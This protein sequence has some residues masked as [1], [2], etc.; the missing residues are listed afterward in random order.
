MPR[1]DGRN[2]LVTGASTGIGRATALMLADLG[3][4]VYAG[5]RDVASGY[6]LGPKV[7]P[8]RLDVTNDVDVI[9]VASRIERL[10]GLVNNAGIAITGPLE[11]LPLDELRRQL[12]VNAIAALAVT[13]ACL[14]A[15]RRARGRIVNVSS[16]SGRSVLPLSG[17]YAASKYAL[18]A[19]S[20]ALRRELRG[21]GVQVSVVQPGSIATPIWER[22][23]AKADELWEAMPSTAH[24]RYGTLVAIVRAEA[25]RQPTA[26]APPE[27]VARVIAGALT[28]RR[29]RTRY[30][31]GR[32]AKARAALAQVLP[33]RAMDA[34]LAAALRTRR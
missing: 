12:E 9:D 28:A 27:T 16:I 3:A 24:E 13:Q 30:P 11:F 4:T 22:G 20:D 2:V 8:V 25:A 7:R 32:D 21:S 6:A 5:T 29:P 18:E 33:G 10:D 1:L 31:V 19:L 17:P 15:L 23:L 26:G 14:P 34:L